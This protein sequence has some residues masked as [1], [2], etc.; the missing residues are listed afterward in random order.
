VRIAILSRLPAV[1]AGLAALLAEQFEV[2]VITSDAPQSDAVAR[3]DVLLAD[4]DTLPSADQVEHWLQAYQPRAGLLLMSNLTGGP[5]TGRALAGV[6]RATGA[7]SVTYGIIPRDVIIEELI[8]AVMAV[9]NGLVVLDRTSGD[10]VLAAAER[11]QPATA[12][13]L[14]VEDTLTARELEV[15]Q[16]L[17]EG[18]PNKLIA[19]RLGISE[20]TAKFHVSA[21]MTKLGATS[22]TEAVTIAARRGLLIL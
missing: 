22:R 17:A 18:L 13:T 8:A 10:E 15:L 14:E 1:R 9:A 16:L 12:T 7:H 19:L 20:H 21:I 5:A 3:T 11:A 2:S 4:T 6:A